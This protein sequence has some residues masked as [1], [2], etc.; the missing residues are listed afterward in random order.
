[1][2]RKRVVVRMY[3]CWALGVYITPTLLRMPSDCVEDGYCYD[4]IVYDVSSGF[5]CC[6]FPV[7]VRMHIE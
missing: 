2:A 5:P 3:W 7:D 4:S 1:M 6:L